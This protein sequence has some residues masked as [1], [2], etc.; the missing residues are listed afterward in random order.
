MI[1]QYIQLYISDYTEWNGSFWIMQGK[2]DKK[3]G[4]DSFLSM[5]V[6]I[7]PHPQ[8]LIILCITHFLNLSVY[9]FCKTP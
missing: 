2:F 1:L 8:A 9:I 5:Y 3:Q 7:K 4:V 6:N